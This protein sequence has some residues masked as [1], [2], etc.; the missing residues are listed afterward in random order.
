MKRGQIKVTKVPHTQVK[1]ASSGL[2]LQ[3]SPQGLALANLSDKSP[4]M[5]K[6]KSQ[7]SRIAGEFLVRSVF[8]HRRCG[9]RPI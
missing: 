2:N 3:Y 4:Q 5:K 6:E 8:Y 9:R 1:T 7:P